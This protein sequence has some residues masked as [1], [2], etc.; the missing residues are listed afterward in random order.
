[1]ATQT[2]HKVLLQPNL[3]Q[4]YKPLSRLFCSWVLQ[5]GPTVQQ[6]APDFKAMAVI[7]EDFEEI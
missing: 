4:Q 7:G 5:Q 3:L 1:M 6:Y 2:S